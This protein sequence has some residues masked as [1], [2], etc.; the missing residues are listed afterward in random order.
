M[1]N[2]VIQLQSLHLEVGQNLTFFF[3]LEI[4]VMLVETVFSFLEHEINFFF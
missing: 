4:R 2:K 3:L 1:K